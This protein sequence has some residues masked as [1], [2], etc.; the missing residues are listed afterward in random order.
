MNVFFFLLGLGFFEFRV[1]GFCFLVLGLGFEGLEFQG[2]G[3]RIFRVFV[4]RRF[5]V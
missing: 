3:L 1:L 2:L 5:R 4:F